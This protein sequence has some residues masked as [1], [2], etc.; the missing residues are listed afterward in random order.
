MDNFIELNRSFALIPKD[1]KFN[2]DTYEYSLIF[3]ISEEK[4]WNDLLKLHRGIILAEAG[5]GKTEEIQAITKK[6]RDEGNKAFF[7][8]LEHL[9]SNFEASFEVGTASEFEKWLSSD[10]PAWFFLDSVDEARLV[11]PKNFETAIR[12]FG[13][14][15]NDNKQRCR[16]FIT[17]R[18]SEWRAQSDLF[19]ITRHLPF[20]ETTS[21]TEEK[22]EKDDLGA[23]DESSD[24]KTASVKKGE[25]KPIE[26]FVFSLLPLDQDQIRTFTQ[27]FGIHNVDAFLDALKRTEADIFAR[28]PLDLI[29]LI[30]Y[31]TNSGKIANRAKLI[32]SS[33][34][35][36]LKEDDS[37]RATAFPLTFDDAI[38]GAE[39]IAADVSFQRKDRILIPEQNIEPELKRGSINAESVLSNWDSKQIR[40]ILQRPVFDKAIYGTVRFH[41][42]SVR[43][44][45]TAKWLHRLLTNGKS[46]RVIEGLFFKEIYGQTVLVPSMRPILS[47]LILFDDRIR[48]K[49]ARLAPEVFIQGGDPSAL[50]TEFRKNMLERFCNIY[51]NQGMADL[52]FELSELRRFAHKDLEN[53]V[54]CLLEVHSHNENIREL[55]LRIVWQ[56]NLSGCSD[57]ALEFALGDTADIYTR[58]CGIRAIGVVGSE[59][60]KNTLIKELLADPAFRQEQ[61]IVELIEAFAPDNLSVQD[62][63]SFLERFDKSG[64][65][66]Y[67]LDY[68]LK[69]CC[70]HKFSTADIITWIQGVLPLIKQPPV[71]ER[72]YFEV[73][74]R[75]G[76]LLPYALIAAERLVIN[77]HP[78]A[79]DDKVLEVISLAQIGNHFHEV[80]LEK[81]DLTD[82]V[83]KWL[84][85]NHALFWF[86]V[87]AAR[88]YLDKKK[89]ERLTNWWQALIF[90]H[91]WRF[92]ED[93]YE[94]FLEDTRIK[95][96][97][98]DRLVA[99]S[100]AFEIYK[101]AGRGRARLQKLKSAVFGVPELEKTLHLYLHPP[102]MSNEQKRSRGWDT[103]FKRRKKERDKKIAENKRDWCE[104]IQS[105]T[106]VLRDTSIASKGKAWNAT[107][108]LMEEI[109]NKRK[110]RNRWATSSWEDLIPEFG[111][112]VAYAFRDGCMNY[113][114]KYQPKI[115]SEG[116]EDPNSRPYAV[117]V[118]LSGLDM[119][120]RQNPKWPYYIAE[121]E[122]KLACRYALH[123]MNGFPDWFRR[124]HTAFP[125]I[126]EKCVL[127]EVKWEFSQY[128]GKESCHYVLD[129]VSWHLE[130]IK[131]RISSQ[132]LSFMQRY[133]PKHDDA[134]EKAL[135]IVLSDPNLDRKAF[136]DIAKTVVHRSSSLYRKA[137]WLAA[138]MRIEA[139][140]ALRE[141]TSILKKITEAQKATELSINFIVA[142][143]GDSR[144]STVSA[145][146]DFVHPEIL[147]SLIKLMHTHIRVEDDISRVGGRVF[148]PTFRDDAQE[149]RGRLFQLLRDIPGKATYSAMIDLAEYHPNE[150]M[151]K[152]CLIHAKRRAEENSEGEP[153]DSG[154]IALFSEEAERPPKNHRELYDLSISRLL[155]LKADLEEGDTSVAEIL[156]SVKE[157]RKHRNM[158]GGWLRDR[159]FGRYNVPQ[160]DE[161]ADRKKPDIRIF[162]VGFDGPVPI[163]LK[164][165]DNC[166]GSK[167][168]ERLHNQLCGQYLRDVRSN[169]GIFALVYRGEK[170]KWQ[171]P[172]TGRKLKFGSLVKLLEKEV[173]EI[174]STNDKIE[175][176]KII[177]IDLTK[178]QQ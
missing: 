70:Q 61:L 14:R 169:C 119:E 35:T 24:G 23:L 122:A 74:R 141:I 175:S 137:L 30:D 47:W 92:D 44:Y 26:P 148:T 85:L 17:S 114:R 28:R 34:I 49:T 42:R 129:A 156:I 88:N 133:E 113:W 64:G 120:A 160:E 33:I 73:S 16:I 97:M 9:C 142:L 151:R 163:E 78:N 157:E 115:R 71:I 125:D 39:M 150:A 99:L 102:P 95:S 77:R 178:R 126:V 56:G 91:F 108:Y 104:R 93:D 174:I 162:G 89:N 27:A 59:E 98:D 4:K 130:W 127:D 110:S 80:H 58:A 55:L 112:D 117:S 18:L 143:L 46:R 5:A 90:G 136:V 8:R 1:Y 76:W 22:D 31:W 87:N 65:R 75:Y 131:P 68:P 13:Y 48:D 96:N 37:D 152:R 166:T 123:E 173:G 21:T 20:F 132:I 153:W 106:H 154:D 51:S 83:P 149:A 171:H 25:T 109:R 167:L 63:L 101:E 105:H 15:L 144:E 62:I 172:K 53:T 100:L 138:W 165:A 161:L 177:D 79:L 52:S 147:L 10:E 54:S 128:D 2:E 40:A 3:G 6:L 81:H 94:A 135:G 32:E 146:Q 12:T 170:K 159:A 66:S 50:P 134:F 155:D 140:T 116:I 29:D 107:I 139:K 41:H 118:G 11:G 57:K 103:R 69:E 72:R 158:I 145:Y 168:V 19:L 7:F 82:L 84:E 164:V 124:L 121:D 38:E 86:D 45:L 43:E 36:K 60:Q 67:S 111:Q 176:I